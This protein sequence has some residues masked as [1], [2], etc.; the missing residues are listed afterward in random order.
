MFKEDDVGVG[1]GEAPAADERALMAFDHGECAIP[2]ATA[3]VAE[4]VGDLHVFGIGAGFL[5]GA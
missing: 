4:E 5:H 1:D 3:E 2:L